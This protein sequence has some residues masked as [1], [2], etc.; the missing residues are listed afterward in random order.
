MDRVAL[1]QRYLFCSSY[2]YLGDNN[3]SISIKLLHKGNIIQAKREQQTE[4]LILNVCIMRVISGWS[5]CV[6]S[7]T[8]LQQ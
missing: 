3:I 1:I 6:L 5:H 4:C 8:W 2:K 7:V